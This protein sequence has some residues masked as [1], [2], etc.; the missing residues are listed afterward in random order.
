MNYCMDRENQK[1]L[2]LLTQAY[3]STDHT[4]MKVV[5]EMAR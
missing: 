5:T 3:S 4:D 2:H 1:K